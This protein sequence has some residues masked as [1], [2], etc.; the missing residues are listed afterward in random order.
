M[1]DT[2]PA[3]LRIAADLRAQ[4]M[5]GTLTPG[6][7]LPSTSQLIARYSAANA[8][9]QAAVGVLKDEGFLRSEH[10]IGVFV[11]DRHVFSIDPA[12]YYDPATRG[13]T[14]K[15]LDVREV[16]PPADVAAALGEK[17][18]ALR[19]RRTDRSGEAVELS[20]S[21]YP[22]TLAAGTPLTGRA[23][24]PGGAPRVLAD[25]GYPELSFSDRVTSRM[26]TTEEVEGLD[27][28]PNVPV[29]RQFRTVYS[30]DRRPVEVSVI[31]KPAHLYELNYERDIPSE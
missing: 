11:R 24:I 20:W 13:V 4:I 16:E 27:V 15:M 14:Y 19:H 26:P 18:A 25:L 21:Y 2:R 12:A 3:H 1:P 7:K 6:Q 30:H 23:K 29:L 22:M 17:R 10:G 9:I 8:T 28:P 31:V 5:A